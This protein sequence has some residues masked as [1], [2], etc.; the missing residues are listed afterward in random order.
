MRTN[1]FRAIMLVLLMAV[2]CLGTMNAQT[3]T[4]TGIVTD[5]A[6]GTSITGCSVVNNRS[7]SGAITDVN[8][9]YSIRPKR[10]RIVIPVYRV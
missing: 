5:A 6:D 9:R 4:V 8:G 3:I 10:G 2:I 7:K 1:Q